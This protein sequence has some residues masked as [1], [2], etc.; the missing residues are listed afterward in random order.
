M[1]KTFIVLISLLICLLLGAGS[2]SSSNTSSMKT[3]EDGEKNP[4]SEISYGPEFDPDDFISG[5]NHTYLPFRPGMSWTYEGETE[6]G[7]GRVEVAVL[8]DTRTVMGVE[9]MVVHDIE[10]LEG[11]VIEDT[12][13][14]FAQDIY[15]NVW[16]F[17]EDSKELED[18]E[19][20]ST[21]GS[22][23]SGVDGALPGIIMPNSPESG[24]TYRQE[25]YRG[26][27]EDMGTVVG[28]DVSVTLPLG[29]FEHCLRTYDWSMI[30]PSAKEYKYYAPGIGLILETDM[31]DNESIELTEFSGA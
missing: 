4:L 24:M 9:C 31:E 27:A 14:L 8:N 17:G 2:S 10:S 21:A 15:G 7:T 3:T 6:D 22:W 19:V 12:Y 26:V 23:E 11:E 5:I 16:Y 28:T 13:D 25:Y 30:E 18:G 29:T 20:V 1:K